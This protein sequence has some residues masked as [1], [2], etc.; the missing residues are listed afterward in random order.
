MATVLFD[1]VVGAVESP[2]PATAFISLAEDS[3][4][5][6]LNTVGF[7]CDLRGSGALKS[8]PTAHPAKATPQINARN[9]AF[10]G[11]RSFR[12]SD[13][14]F[15]SDFVIRI[16]NLLCRHNRRP[17]RNSHRLPGRQRIC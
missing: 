10:V 14:G 2:R 16:S 8:G 5:A 11:R 7:G 13:F 6:P 3:F 4:V 15:V 9:V 12:I 17:L 1:S